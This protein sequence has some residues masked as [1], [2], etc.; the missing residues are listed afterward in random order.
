MRDEST[1]YQMILDVANADEHILRSCW[2][3]MES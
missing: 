3:R 2:T 1:M